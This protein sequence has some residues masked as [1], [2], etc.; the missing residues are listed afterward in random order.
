MVGA[1]TNL[2]KPGHYTEHMH[3]SFHKINPYSNYSLVLILN[4]VGA[5]RHESYIKHRINLHR[6]SI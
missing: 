5:S 1:Q 6:R 3:R 4:I 2:G